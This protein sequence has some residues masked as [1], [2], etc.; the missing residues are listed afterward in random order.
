MKI[1]PPKRAINF[2]R[3]FCREDY[4]DEIEGDLIEIF[5]M[6]FLEKPSK[7]NRFFWW[8]VIL[9]FRPD[10]FKKIQVLIF[11]SNAVSMN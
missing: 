11:I 4:L 6:R 3:W 1:E 10:Y 2:L 8:Q 5:E 7:A 9:H